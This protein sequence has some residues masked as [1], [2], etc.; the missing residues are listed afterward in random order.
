MKMK[1]TTAH[2]AEPT[3]GMTTE[4][5]VSLIEEGKDYSRVKY[6]EKTY[7]VAT[8]HVQPEIRSE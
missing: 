1:K 4:T 3:V 5:T 7:Y 6:G 2:V 8:K